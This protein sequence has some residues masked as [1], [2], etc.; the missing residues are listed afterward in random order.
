MSRFA[1]FVCVGAFA[2]VIA[3]STGVGCSPPEK[4]AEIGPPA[5]SN[6]RPDPVPESETPSTE[7]T[8]DPETDP[9][10]PKSWPLFRGNSF[11]TGIASSNLP[12]S[13]EILWKFT[14]KDSIEG[15]PAIVNGV[16][17][18]GSMDENF[19]ALDLKTGAEKWKVKLGP[20]KAPVSF[21][22]GLLY[23]GDADG[24]FHC[25]EAANGKERWKFTTDGEISSGANFAGE[26]VLFG[27]GDEN[28]YCLSVKEGKEV[29]KF[30]VAGG[31]VMGTPAVAGN[32]TFAAG[33]D[34]TLHILDV[35]TGKEVS[36][37]ELPGQVGASLAVV[38]DRAYFGTM[39]NQVL[40]VD[41][42]K[43][44]VVWQ[45][46]S[47][48]RQQ[49]FFSSS[50]VT[51]SLVITGSRDKRVHA[52]DRKGGQAVWTFPT[53]GKVDSS[54][55]VVGNRVFAASLDG[56]LYVLDLA[57]GTELKKFDLGAGV[58]G[59]PAVGGGCLVVG[60]EKGVL[61]CLGAKK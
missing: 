30:K 41:W 29:W 12:E 61:Y 2:V 22:D 54:P 56:K 34:S 16:V 18:F 13:P 46:E 26:T 25:L 27:S 51:D 42:K 17:Y 47:D 24:I 53:E 48:K 55:V 3:F 40:A 39:T 1:A 28:L 4:G 58:L 33:C 9:R 32:R 23:V 10:N 8:R 20:V 5:T 59:S 43:P 14:T 36:S 31:P 60:T 45:Y 44:A 50:A 21:R 37:V 35:G 11:Q 15:A 19:Y 6:S 38:G 7:I 57:K 52:L 49:P